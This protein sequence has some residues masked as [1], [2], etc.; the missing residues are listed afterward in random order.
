MKQKGPDIGA[1]LLYLNVVKHSKCSKQRNFILPAGTSRCPL[2][3][4]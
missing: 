3:T 2:H 4:F 1:F